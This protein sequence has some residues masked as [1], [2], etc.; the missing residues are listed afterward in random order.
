MHFS[1]FV[2][3][4]SDRAGFCVVPL[5]ADLVSRLILGFLARARLYRKILGE[6][7]NFPQEKTSTL[8]SLSSPYHYLAPVVP[9]R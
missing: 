1:S 4:A 9:R 8:S 5:A 6:S 3:S 7:Q 2:D